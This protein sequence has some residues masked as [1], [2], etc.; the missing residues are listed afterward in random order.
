M[1]Y[2]SKMIPT[3]DFSRFFA[4]GRVFSGTVRGG[5]KVYILGPNYVPG[6]KDDKYEKTIQRTVLMMGKKIELM[7]DVPCGNTVGLVGVDDC[8]IKSA[9]ITTDAKSHNIRGMKY[10]VSPVVRV[11]VEPKNHADLPKLVEGLRR[12]SKYDALVQVSTEASGQ[13]IIAGCGE[14]HVEICLHDLKDEFAKC[15]FNVSDPIVSYCETITEKSS[16]TCLSKSQNNHNRLY[17]TAEPLDDNLV[18]LIEKGKFGPKVDVKERVRLLAEEF[19]WDRTDALKVW[20]FGPENSGANMLV[21]T[22]KG[23]QYVNEIQ[24]SVESAFQAVTKEGVLCEE[25]LRGGRFNITDA[26]LHPDGVHR[27]AGQLIPAAR[28]VC[29]AS[30]ITSQSRLLEPVF[31]VDIT[32]PVEAT[33]G[34][35]QCL[36]Q[37]RGQVQEEIPV[38][39]TPLKLIKA[40]LPVAESF[41]FAMHLRSLT[42][43]QAF[44]QCVFDH[45]EVI[46]ADPFQAGS[47]AN[48]IVLDIRK[49]KGRKVE[50]PNLMDYLDKL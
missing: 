24:D 5:Q 29:Y 16:Q 27:G 40:Y 33:S 32:T 36:S 41:G 31:M 37:R 43:G 11:A 1:M 8:I 49:R 17:A 44:P 48:Q 42:A 7:Q 35:Y 28:R 46:K 10:S 2:V 18:D 22:T 21:D 45:W 12:L 4:F 34:V 3:A 19:N 20:C 50:L 6:S 25:T 23:I 13:H 26:T 47:R 30:Q 39:G 15:D 9:T 38:A 14:L